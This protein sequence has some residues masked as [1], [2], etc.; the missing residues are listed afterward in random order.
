VKQESLV[1]NRETRRDRN[2]ILS[3]SI[4]SC[5]SHVDNGILIEVC[6]LNFSSL[7]QLKE[8]KKE[9]KKKKKKD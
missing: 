3:F 6:N 1:K 4:V 5:K 8:K 2:T 9:K 7:F